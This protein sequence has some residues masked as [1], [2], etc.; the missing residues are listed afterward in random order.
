M[1][2]AI[3]EEQLVR[4][5]EAL[6][7]Y[8]FPAKARASV[9]LLPPGLGGLK[10]EVEPNQRQRFIRHEIGGNQYL[11]SFERR[12]TGCARSEVFRIDGV[13]ACDPSR[14]VNEERFHRP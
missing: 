5:L 7:V 2:V 14:G 4:S 3:V 9:D 12:V 10:T 1:V 11:A 6:G 8:A 13:G